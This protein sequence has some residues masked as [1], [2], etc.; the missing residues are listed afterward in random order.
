[1]ET[2]SS[3]QPASDQQLQERSLPTMANSAAA[4]AKRA[5]DNAQAPPATAEG[6]ALLL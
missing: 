1:M 6:D 4:S 2:T 3:T 5:Q